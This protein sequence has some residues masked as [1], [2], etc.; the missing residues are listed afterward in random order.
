MAF[1]VQGTMASNGKK[2]EDVLDK[3]EEAVFQTYQA[4]QSV[5]F[6]LHMRKWN[7]RDTYE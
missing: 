5:I 4:G 7:V 1:L 2:L 3:H 6:V